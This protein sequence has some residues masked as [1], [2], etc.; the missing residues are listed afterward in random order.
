MICACSLNFYIAL[1][2]PTNGLQRARQTLLGCHILLDAQSIDVDA[3]RCSFVVPQV[4]YLRLQFRDSL[5]EQHRRQGRLDWSWSSQDLLCSRVQEQ[6]LLGPVVVEMRPKLPASITGH[7]PHI[8]RPSNHPRPLCQSSI[9][10]PARRFV[11]WMMSAQ[12]MSSR[13]DVQATPL[14]FPRR[15]R[16]I[17]PL[18]YFRQASGGE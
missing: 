17:K 2:K 18:G 9:F 14:Q 12:L 3:K 11:L 1:K 5:Y 8:H 6:G 13:D 7:T 15:K 10:R 16:L 4:Q